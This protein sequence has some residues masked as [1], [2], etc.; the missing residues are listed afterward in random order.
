MAQST[1]HYHSTALAL[2]AVRAPQTISGVVRAQMYS[3]RYEITLV[4]AFIPSEVARKPAN[5]LVL[6]GR[7]VFK[8]L[9][10]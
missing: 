6:K 10:S 5:I 7:T 4:V 2:E 8:G 9:C 1:T 3:L